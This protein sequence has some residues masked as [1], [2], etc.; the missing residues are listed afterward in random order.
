MSIINDRPRTKTAEQ[1]KAEFEANGKSISQWAEANGFRAN[2]VYQVLN[3]FTKANR[4][5]AHQIAVAL[6]IK[7]GDALGDE[8]ATPATEEGITKLNLMTDFNGQNHAELAEKYGLS[9]RAVYKII[10]IVRPFE[11]ARKQRAESEQN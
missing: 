4:G 2:A 9:M 10:E 6:G 5:Q 11:Q 8:I 7:A 1:V 3:G